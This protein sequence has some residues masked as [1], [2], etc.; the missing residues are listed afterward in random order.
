MKQV[1]KCQNAPKFGMYQKFKVHS[2]LRIIKRHHYWHPTP[3]HH[4]Q[5]NHQKPS[6]SSFPT[7]Q[8]PQPHQWQGFEKQNC[9]QRSPN[10]EEKRWSW[11]II[12]MISN[13]HTTHPAGQTAWQPWQM[14]HSQ[15]SASQLCS[16]TSPGTRTN[17]G[18]WRCFSHFG[19]PCHWKNYWRWPWLYFPLMRS[20]RGRWWGSSPWGCCCHSP[21]SS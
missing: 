12:I 4:H 9:C 2:K 13:G 5:Q 11:S 19:T 20:W 17:P 16:S 8:A 18:C 3:D 15:T 10:L 6:P 1:P 14:C 21:L 7:F